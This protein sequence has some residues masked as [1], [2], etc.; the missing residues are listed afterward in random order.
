QFNEP[1]VIKQTIARFSRHGVKEEQLVFKKAVPRAEYLACYNHVDIALDPFPYCGGTTTA[2]ALWMGVP[3]L[4]LPGEQF[5]SRQGLG[6]LIN[7]GLPEWVAED[8]N[9]YVQRAKRYAGDLQYLTSTRT[10]LRNKVLASPIFDAE[11]FAEHMESALRAIWVD[12]CSNQAVDS[13]QLHR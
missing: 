9:D 10:G 6:L 3:V 1:A 13:N 2:E 8:E 4:T 12:W 5:L 11:R 7:A